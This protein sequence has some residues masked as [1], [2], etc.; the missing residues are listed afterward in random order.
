MTSAQQRRLYQCGKN[1]G[2]IDIGNFQKID[3]VPGAY[4]AAGFRYVRVVL[5]KIA[6]N[7]TQKG[8]IVIPCRWAKSF[9]RLGILQKIINYAVIC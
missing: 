9:V 2:Q 3:H 6:R 8:E 4:Q 7:P 5:H 1:G